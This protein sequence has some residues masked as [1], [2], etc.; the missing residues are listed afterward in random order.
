M[1]L[2]LPRLL[3]F[4]YDTP[5]ASVSSDEMYKDKDGI[6]VTMMNSD[7]C[8]DVILFTAVAVLLES[9]A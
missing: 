1:I 6:F 8:F 3:R 5:D 7:G 2:L 9:E 4:R